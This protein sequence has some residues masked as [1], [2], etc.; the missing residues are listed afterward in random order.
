M[1][2]L[3]LIR[4]GQ[5][6]ANLLKHIVG[7]RS[8]Y[9]PLTELGEQQAKLLGN[10]LKKENV[11]FEGVYSSI[12]ERA[13]D[14]AKIVCNIIGFPLDQIILSEDFQ[15]QSHGS[16]EGCLRDDIWT[17]ESLKSWE[18]DK[19]NYALP[20]G[21]S[22]KNAGKRWYDGVEKYLLNKNG[23]YAIFGHGTAIRCF[24]AELFNFTGETILS[25]HTGNTSISEVRYDNG[26]WSLKRLNDNSHL[27]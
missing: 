5:C 20:S 26:Q 2:E 15:E 22:L 16:Y 17:P 18:K 19:H 9:S 8:N 7:G 13:K 24:L 11:N 1:L 21:E 25:L 3:Y 12:A 14:T 6:E 10:R 4:H 23:T 27:K